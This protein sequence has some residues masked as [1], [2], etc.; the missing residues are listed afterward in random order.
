[1]GRTLKRVPL[2]FD[3]PLKEMWHG[4]SNP[5][6]KNAEECEACDRTGYAPDALLLYRQWYGAQHPQAGF[7]PAL[8]GSDPFSTDE[9]AIASCAERNCTSQL[10][11]F[12][13]VSF[14]FMTDEGRV[15]MEAQRLADLYNAAWSHHL[16][17]DDVDA[18]VKDGRLHDFTHT[19][20]KEDGWVRR[21]DGYVP[22]AREVNVWSLA[23]MGHD[24]I[25]Q[26]VCIEARCE[27]MG[28]E[29]TC[30]VCKGTGEIWDSKENEKKCED[31]VETE[32][33]KGE[34]Y[35]L[36]ETTS[37]GSPV[38]P[39]F[40]TLEDLCEWCED[41]AT[42]FADMKASKEEWM[43]MLNDDFVHAR[44][45]NAKKNSEIILM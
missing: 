24:A 9:P 15:K 38:S 14:P 29:K 40:E 18:L 7:R 42:T 6:Y 30:P 36:W 31:W 21:E 44:M 23:G 4:Y 27:R 5:Y 8:T 37:E 20:S 2:D 16:N 25:N 11:G 32:P 22:T 17:Q 34:G 39:V 13:G 28:F 33:P 10:S 1:M 26:H 35:Q 12:G 19:W 45:V 3:W 41:N 43:E